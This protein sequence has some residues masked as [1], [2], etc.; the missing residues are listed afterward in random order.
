MRTAPVQ[1]AAQRLAEDWS[2]TPLN[3]RFIALT[4]TW[5]SVAIL[6]DHRLDASDLPSIRRRRPMPA[7]L[8]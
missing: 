6:F 7:V 5:A 4:T 3:T 8:S 1:P 2:G